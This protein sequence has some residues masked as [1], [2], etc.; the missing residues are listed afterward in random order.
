MPNLD[1]TGP[2]GEGAK[3]GRNLGNCDCPDNQKRFFGRFCRCG[4][5]FFRRNRK[6]NQDS[7]EVQK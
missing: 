1:G 5:G 3:T 7:Q 4:R 6:I 2:Q